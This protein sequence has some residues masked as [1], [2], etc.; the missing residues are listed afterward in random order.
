MKQQKEDIWE[1]IEKEKKID[2]WITRISIGSWAATFILITGFTI[3]V[4]IETIQHYTTQLYPLGS[5]DNLLMQI[6]VIT[7]PFSAIGLFTFGAAILS[8]IGLFIRMRTSSLRDIQ[9]R[10]GTLEGAILS[11]ED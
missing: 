9:L 8:T 1:K 6:A 10:L 3:L 11:K 2:K 5:L 7:I 4:L